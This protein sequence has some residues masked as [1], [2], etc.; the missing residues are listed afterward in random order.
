[1]SPRH[2]HFSGLPRTTWEFHIGGYQ[3]LEKWLKDRRGR[4]LTFDDI[5]HWQ[6][7]AVALAKTQRIMA[8]IDAL[9][10][11]WPSFSDWLVRKPHDEMNP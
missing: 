11:G 5:Q 6:R 9:I 10:P 1:M 8:E 3:V 2:Q 7:T 4:T